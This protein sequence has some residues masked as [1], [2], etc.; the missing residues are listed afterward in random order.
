M[1][2]DISRKF[3]SFDFVYFPIFCNLVYVQKERGN[4]STIFGKLN[5]SGVFVCFVYC[6]ITLLRIIRL[7]LRR[8]IYMVTVVM[9]FV[10]STTKRA[11]CFFLVLAQGVEILQSVHR[12]LKIYY[13]FYFIYFFKKNIFLFVIY[14]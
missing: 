12:L 8:R 3:M 10:T 9:P 5:S 14:F 7:Y 4:S 13:L 2:Y 6:R 1:S 11:P